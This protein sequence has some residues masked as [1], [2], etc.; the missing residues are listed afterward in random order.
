MSKNSLKPPPTQNAQR[1]KP[2]DGN[3]QLWLL[4]LEKLPFLDPPFVNDQ[5]DLIPSTIMEHFSM[6]LVLSRIGL[7][8]QN[9]QRVYGVAAS[10]LIAKYLT[11]YGWYPEHSGKKAE[12]WFLKEARTL[13]CNF[14]ADLDLLSSPVEYAIALQK[15]GA[16]VN[17][18]T[19][20]PGEMYCQDVVSQILE[21]DLLECDYRY[22]T[23]GLYDLGKD[24]QFPRPNDL[25]PED[26]AAVL[27]CSVE[28]ASRL[29]ESGELTGC[30]E[31]PSTSDH[32]T[33]RGPQLR[34]YVQ[35]DG[36][37]KFRNPA[38]PGL[39]LVPEPA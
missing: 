10:F 24:P 16:L 4:S 33:V 9:A 6:L 5:S 36:Y 13:R 15:R 22:G 29:Y 34:A 14:P 8:A 37:R 21:H 32:W 26:V 1:E 30:R 27:G 31:M 7:A 2:L 12:Q 25:C 35:R 17:S 3:T 20:E 23:G 18:C 28:S 38:A 19:G 39:H 11:D